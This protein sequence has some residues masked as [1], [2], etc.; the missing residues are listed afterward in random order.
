MRL[1]TTTAALLMTLTLSSQAVADVCPAE[2]LN[3]RQDMR[4]R[5]AHVSRRGLEGDHHYSIAF[6]TKAKGVGLPAALISQ[7]PDDMHIILQ[8]QFEALKVSADR[9]DVT[10]WFKGKKTRVT[11]PFDAV[12][13]FLDP[14]VNFRVEPDPAFRGIACDTKR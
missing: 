14:S 10:L 1:R 5:L 8:Y 13:L 9:F 7:Y 3:Q 12:T 6:K 4:E 11:V 2:V